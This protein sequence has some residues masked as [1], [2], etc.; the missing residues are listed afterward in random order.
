MTEK[1][2]RLQH[3]EFYST[4]SE[5]D[6]SFYS[7]IFWTSALILFFWAL[8]YR[9]L[10]TAEGR[11]AEIVREMLLTGDFFHPRI[12]G[13][14]YFDKPLLSYWFIALITK[15]TGRFDE[16]TVRLPSAVSG[17]L[18]LWATVSLGRRLWSAR[19]G[20]TAGWILMTTYG[21]LFRARTGEADMEYL[22]AISIAV[23]WYWMR[24][25]KFNFITWLVFYLV[26]FSGAQT[27]GLAAIAMPV[28]AILPDIIEKRRWRILLTPSHYLALVIGIIF[29]L[30]PFVCADLA[31]KGYQSS[32]L[33]LMFKENII[34]YFQPLDHKK[35]FYIYFYYLPVL[36]MPWTPLLIS[37]I[38]GAAGSFKN[39]DKRTKWLIKATAL[40]FL[41]FTFSGS[42]RSYYI[43]PV[44]PF[45]ALLVSVYM[46]RQ[47]RSSWKRAVFSFQKG[48]LLTAAIIEIVS[49]LIWRFLENNFGF[50]AP[51][52]LK[53]ITPVIGFLAIIPFIL[54]YISPY[55][56]KG[57]TENDLK[58]GSMIVSAAIIMGGFFCCQQKNFE[59]YRTEKKFAENLKESIA[60]LSVEKIAFYRKVSPNILFYLDLPGYTGIL[61]TPASVSNF[62]K[63]NK[64]IK[65]LIS[66]CKYIPEF[67]PVFP[68]GHQK[69]PV[70]SEKTYP[71]QKPVSRKLAA[72]KF[73]TNKKQPEDL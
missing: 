20:R 65:I 3:T 49:P 14:P 62:L 67:L 26:C 61:K 60:E 34:R 54:E 27:K 48:L 37:I 64:R 17:L 12:N 6:D 51:M 58:T 10:W 63:Q 13:V 11:W 7:V 18:V 24:R 8:S 68:L 35:P 43:L 57:F 36:F 53:L 38:P 19:I 70:L 32:G 25:E 28:F 5:A 46:L 47:D 23:A 56:L 59:I 33:Y 4:R 1:S 44:L 72:W 30:F 2:K 42:R 22:A 73:G 9:G 39:S 16:W 69:L 71:W 31:D 29:Y 21:F 52:N 15:I 55:F 66:R 50:A 40:I 41:F 45:C